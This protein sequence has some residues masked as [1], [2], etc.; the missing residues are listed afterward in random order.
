MIACA[1]EYLNYESGKFSKSHNRGVFGPAAKETGIP[2]CVWRYYLLSTR[3]ETADAMFSWDDCVSFSH[4]WCG[5]STYDNVHQVAAN[6]NVLLNKCVPC[7]LDFFGFDDRSASVISSTEP[8]NSFHP[9]TVG[10]SRK[11]IPPDLSRLTMRSTPSLSQLSM[12]F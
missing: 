9:N 3:P 5:Q 10:P 11:A 7:R 8:S 6:N 4:V 12:A 2:P 1:S